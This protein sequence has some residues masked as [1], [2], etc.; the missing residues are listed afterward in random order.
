MDWR[1]SAVIFRPGKFTDFK[2]EGTEIDQQTV[3]ESR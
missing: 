1:L 2:L 3:F